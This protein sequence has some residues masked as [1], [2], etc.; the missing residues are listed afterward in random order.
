[1]ILLENRDHSLKEELKVKESRHLFGLFKDSL[2]PFIDQIKSSKYIVWIIYVSFI[3]KNVH[4]NIQELVI[5]ED[6]Q[7]SLFKC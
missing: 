6:L 7:T 4:H 3:I 2:E 1:M 5:I